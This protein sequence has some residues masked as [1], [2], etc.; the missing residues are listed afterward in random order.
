[1]SFAREQSGKGGFQMR[2]GNMYLEG[3]SMAVGAGLM[4]AAAVLPKISQPVIN[5]ITSVRNKI[6]GAK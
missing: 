4:F 1:M 6:G 5:L 2:V 3:K